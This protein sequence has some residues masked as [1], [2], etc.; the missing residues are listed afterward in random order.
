VQA[1]DCLGLCTPRP[2]R[3]HP[4]PQ[5]PCSFHGIQPSKNTREKRA[6]KAAEEIAK[7]RV[8]SEVGVTSNAGSLEQMKQVGGRARMDGWGGVKWLGAMGWWGARMMGTQ[9]VTSSAGS[10]SR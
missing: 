2:L 6:K 1:S 9:C 7:K 8:A 3:L 4:R 5:L 10:W